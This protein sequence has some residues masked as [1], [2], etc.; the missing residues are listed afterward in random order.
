MVDVNELKQN[1][2]K[3]NRATT[4]ASKRKSYLLAE[5]SVEA[6]ESE[7]DVI[8][9]ELVSKTDELVQ[10]RKE[11]L[12]LKQD[13]NILESR[14]KDLINEKLEIEKKLEVLSRSRSELSST[15][16]VKAFSDS[17]DEME[18]SL[19]SESSR[20]E[21]SVSSMN[22]KL[23][24]NIAMEGNDLRF[25]LPKADDLIPAN[26]L[27]EVQFTISSSSK[28]PVLSSLVDVPDVV[29][30]E[31][32]NALAAIKEA[33][34][35][36][37][38][39]IEKESKFVQGTVLSQIPSGSSVAKSGDA[40]DLVI[41]KITS[42]EVPDMTG[43]TLAVA[44]KSLIDSGL[45]LGK[46]T[47]EANSLKAGTVVSQSVEPGTYVDIGDAIDLVVASSKTEFAAVSGRPLANEDVSRFASRSVLRNVPR[48]SSTRKSLSRK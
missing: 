28:E 13:Y 2:E 41:S 37:G 34:F 38:E 26:N 25:Q 7:F 14:V 43:N 9:K 8:N 32:D 48:I 15:N 6:I 40:V 39:I 30:F 29:G 21:Y 33:G 4:A 27:S 46:V 16:L 35:N 10:L 19:K 5:R 22:I 17:L 11:N 24:T 20:V 31:L 3:L 23:K 12:S 36:Q 1:L 47:E 45:S 42:V 18:S 44:K